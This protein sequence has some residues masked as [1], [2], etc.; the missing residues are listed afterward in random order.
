MPLQRWSLS[1]E[2]GMFRA[3]GMLISR[4]VGND[5]YTLEEDDVK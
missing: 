4:S 5:S 1:S 3:G 2:V